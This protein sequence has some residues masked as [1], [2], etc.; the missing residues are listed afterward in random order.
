MELFLSQVSVWSYA[1]ATVL[2]G[3]FALYLGIAWRRGR[4]G[5]LL[6]AAVVLSGGWAAA[7]WGFALTGWIWL[8]QLGNLFDVLRQAAWFGFLVAMLLQNASEADGNVAALAWPRPAMLAIVALAAGG[9]ACFTLGIPLYGTPMRTWAATS[10]ASSVFGLVLLEHFYR[11]VPE[12]SHWGIKPL[13]LALGGLFAF[14]VYLFSDALLFTRLHPSVWS[15]RGF[16]HT[17]AIPLIAVSASRNPEW[18]FR[19]SVSRHVV[20]HSTAMAGTGLYLTLIAGAGYYMRYFGGEWGQALQVALLFGGAL[21]LGVVAFSGAV[22]S[23][24]KVLIAKHFFA[25]RYD[26]RTE[27]LG[28][29]Q[30]LSAAGDGLT[31]GESVVNALGDLVESPGGGV[32]LKD[33]A[34]RYSQQA[35]LNMPHCG[36]QVGDDDAFIRF[37]LEKEWVVNLEEARAGVN[38][39]ESQPVPAWIGEVD[40]AWL[41][42]P[43]ISAGSL[44]GFVILLT[45]RTPVD[46]N[47]EVLDLLKT[48]GRQAA[49]YFARMQAAEAL[50][51]ARKFDAFNRMSAFVVHDLKN[52]V[53]QL[54]LMLRNAERHKDN[55]EFQAD[56]LD[57][58]RHVE[59]RMRGLM[60]QLMEKTPI[61][62]RKPVPLTPLLEHIVQS[63]RLFRPAPVLVSGGPDLAVL[64][65]SERLERIVGHIVQNALDATSE[66]GSVSVEVSRSGNFASIRVADTGSGMSAAFIRDQLFKPF[67]TTKASGMGI[68]AYE[69][70]QYIHELGGS[71]SV[72]SEVGAGSCFEIRLPLAHLPGGVDGEPAAKQT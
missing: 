14:D 49:G 35:R 2:H 24:F 18:T 43:L 62:Q 53:A 50:L 58:V 39:G 55:P 28:V 20:L 59:E 37:L 10:L 31:L 17:L 27:W 26:Y 40:D 57:T 34:G 15:V 69:A 46:V 30:A 63:K 68:G 45:P 52:L 54:S 70:R 19:I 44:I 64:A 67:Q 38:F 47:W 9:V 65:H 22:R 48:A 4:R 56:M 1:F 3:L 29:T 6:V 7:S 66:H 16:A 72:E 8:F 42:V 33:A 13:T 12:R 61:N 25:Y 60:A 21:F 36:M 41:I 11:S 51:E 5:W 32:W 71:L 23:R